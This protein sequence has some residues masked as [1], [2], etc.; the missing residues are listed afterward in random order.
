MLVISGHLTVNSD[1]V[2]WLTFVL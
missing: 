2:I 1:M